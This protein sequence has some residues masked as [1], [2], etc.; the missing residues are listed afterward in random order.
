M[1]ASGV[2][3]Q[4]QGL[5]GTLSTAI[6]SGVRGSFTLTL[7]A[8]SAFTT[9]TGATMV[10]VFQQTGTT[11]VGTSSIANSTT[12]HVSGL[13]FFDAGQWKMVAARI[14]S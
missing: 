6:T 4:P 2:V 10:T 7:P 1:A 9:L 12:V 3:L 11:I 14:G 8:Q 13:L 5:K